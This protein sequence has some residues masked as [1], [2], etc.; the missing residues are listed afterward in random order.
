MLPASLDLVDLSLGICC[1]QIPVI[2]ATA[3]ALNIY[4][5]GPEVGKWQLWQINSELTEQCLSDS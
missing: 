5:T 2:E 3:K 1:R 4:N